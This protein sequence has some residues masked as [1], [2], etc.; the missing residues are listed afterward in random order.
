MDR[1]RASMIGG[2]IMA[3]VTVMLCGGW[4]G[5]LLVPEDYP[6]TSGYKVPGIPDAPVDLAAL[7]R[8]WPTGVAEPGE[9]VRLIGYMKRVEHG[10]VTPPPVTGEAAPAAAPAPEVDLGTR[11][12]SANAEQGKGAARVCATCHTT[13]AGGANRVGPNLWN[14]VGRDIASHGGFA[15]SSA[16]TAQPGNWTYERL[17]HYLARPARDV[18]GT[19]MA[20]GG[21]RNATDRANLIAYLATL[22]TAPPPFPPPKP[23]PAKATELSSR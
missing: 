11:L 6:A 14:I 8:S 20:F 7:Q 4:A 10:A 21:I 5:T 15:Y 19:K 2:W 17:D 23:A 22:D 3:A 1:R 16:M 13:N 12:A 9:R 18:P